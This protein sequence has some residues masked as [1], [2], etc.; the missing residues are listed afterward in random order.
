MLSTLNIQN[1]V[2]PPLEVTDMEDACITWVGHITPVPSAIQDMSN[3]FS[4]SSLNEQ[5][6]SMKRKRALSTVNILKREKAFRNLE[7][8]IPEV[9]ERNPSEQPQGETT[10]RTVVTH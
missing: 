2:P 6:A 9:P 10:F 4:A 1:P 8:C 5:S 7:P 3:T